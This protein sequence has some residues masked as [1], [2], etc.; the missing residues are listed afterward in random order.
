MNDLEK[1]IQWLKEKVELLEKIQNLEER[2]S[3]LESQIAINRLNWYPTVTVPLQP[4][5]EPRWTE[6]FYYITCSN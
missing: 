1:E 3:M 5:F 2:I 4:P 6:P